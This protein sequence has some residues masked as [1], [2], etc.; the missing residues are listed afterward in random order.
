M[1]QDKLHVC[2]GQ[3]HFVKHSRWSLTHWKPFQARQE[4]RIA[5]VV[6]PFIK[7]FTGMKYVELDLGAADNRGKGVATAH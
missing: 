2:G 1:S 5:C 7:Y 3:Q 6:T 4:T